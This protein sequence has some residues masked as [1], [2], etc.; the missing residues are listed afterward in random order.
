MGSLDWMM[1]IVLNMLEG[2]EKGKTEKICKNFK[3]RLTKIYV[4]ESEGQRKIYIETRSHFL[5]NF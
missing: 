2:K 4:K 1:Y 3:K 5:F